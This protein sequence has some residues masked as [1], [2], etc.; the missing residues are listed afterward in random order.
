MDGQTLSGNCDGENPVTVIEM[1]PTQSEQSQESGLVIEGDRLARTLN[2]IGTT[3]CLS[4]S[5]LVVSVISF[6]YVILLIIL[7]YTGIIQ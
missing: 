3:E 4:L 6:V 1:D 5:I 7:H 2:E